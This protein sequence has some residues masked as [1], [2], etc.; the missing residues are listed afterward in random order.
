MLEKFVT[1]TST[2]R[3]ETHYFDA[4]DLLIRPTQLLDL[5][6]FLKPY[7]GGL[8]QV[9]DVEQ[10]VVDSEDNPVK[11][12]TVQRLSHGISHGTSLKVET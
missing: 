8:L 9:L 1:C 2:N 10:S 4:A 6:Y 12:S 5:I 3:I 11:Q 7:L